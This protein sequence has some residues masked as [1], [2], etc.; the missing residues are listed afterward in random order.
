MIQAMIYKIMTK[1]LQFK[2]GNFLTIFMMLLLLLIFQA[3]S[4]SH[5]EAVCARHLTVNKVKIRKKPIPFGRSTPS[6]AKALSLAELL[7]SI[8]LFLPN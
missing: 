5:V 8:V 3:P 2:D 4:E 6:L 7:P 1:N